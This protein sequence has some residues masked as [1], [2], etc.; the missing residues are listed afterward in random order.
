MGGYTTK[1]SKKNMVGNTSFTSVAGAGFRYDDIHP[2]EL[3]HTEN[4]SFVG[5][6]QFGRTKELNTNAFVE[7]TIAT[8]KWLFNAG[9]RLDYFHFYYLNMAPAGDTFASK[10]FTG[11]SPTAHRGTLSPKLNIQFSRR[12]GC[13]RSFFR[14]ACVS[15]F[16]QPF[17][18][19]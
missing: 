15:I 17:T 6:L 4:G 2:S 5:Y 12:A 9:L 14:G 11:T 3:D 19:Q 7:E 10:V 18:V 8:G 13:T 16:S 1:I